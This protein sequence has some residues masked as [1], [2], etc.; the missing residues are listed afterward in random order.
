MIVLEMMTM[1]ME[2][3]IQRI[4]TLARKAKTQELTEEEKKERDELRQKYIASVR[5]NLRSQLDNTYVL[6]PDGTKRKLSDQ[7]PKGKS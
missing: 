4:N 5:N 7:P 2:E 6:M 1:T 3:V